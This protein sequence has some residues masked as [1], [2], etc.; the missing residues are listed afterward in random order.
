MD[1]LIINDWGIKPGRKKI[2]NRD[3]KIPL[4]SHTTHCQSFGVSMYLFILM[5]PFTLLLL[6]SF[7]LF[8]EIP[9]MRNLRLKSCNEKESLPD[10]HSTSSNITVYCCILHLLLSSARDTSQRTTWKLIPISRDLIVNRA[11]EDYISFH[12]EFLNLIRGAIGPHTF[13]YRANERN[14]T[15][16]SEMLHLM[17]E[18]AESV[19]NSRK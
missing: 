1:T 2:F 3:Y 9:K 8:K 5:L 15:W 4:R 14:F 16:I 6:S 19:Y 12:Y 18:L 7:N 10:A 11:L 17:M 13:I